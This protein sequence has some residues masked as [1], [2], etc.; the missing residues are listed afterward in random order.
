MLVRDYFQIQLVSWS[1]WKNSFLNNKWRNTIWEMKPVFLAIG[2]L[3]ES[4]SGPLRYQKLIPGR[5]V[6]C[7]SLLCEMNVLCTRHHWLYPMTT[8][9]DE[10]NCP[11]I[12]TSQSRI[13]Y[14][15]IPWYRHVCNKVEIRGTIFLW[16][17]ELK[18]YFSN[19]IT[20]KLKAVA[21]K[22]RYQKE[23]F[24]LT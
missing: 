15:A 17:K 22:R 14:H 8:N 18:D 20:Y 24:Q 2:Y 11:I 16:I 9:P 23:R 3:E 21:F 7:D 13:I 12:V 19:E 1:M 4:H 10:A 5:R 6:I